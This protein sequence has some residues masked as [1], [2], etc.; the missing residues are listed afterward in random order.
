[1]TRR[2]CFATASALLLGV[3]IGTATLAQTTKPAVKQI[4]IDQFDKLRQEKNNVVL[5]VR[6]AQEF[7]QGHVPGAVNV[8]ISDPQFKTKIAALDKSKTYLVHCAK[9]VR[10]ARATKIMAPLGFTDILDYHGGFD[11]WKKSSKPV[12]KGDTKAGN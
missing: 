9:G 8:D 4:D 6:T 5:D 2:T 11:E 1:M 10:S 12:E 3:L 7:N